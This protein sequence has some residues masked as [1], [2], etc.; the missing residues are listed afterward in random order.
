VLLYVVVDPNHFNDS[1]QMTWDSK[2]PSDVWTTQH[3]S[4]YE[5]CRA[6]SWSDYCWVIGILSSSIDCLNSHILQSSSAPVFLHQVSQFSQVKQ[7]LGT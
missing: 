2:V 3:V 6:L 7:S 4:W 1:V 5:H